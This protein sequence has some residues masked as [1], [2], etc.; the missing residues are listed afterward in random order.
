MSSIS[1]TTCPFTTLT[2][3]KAPF[4]LSN[5]LLYIKE[6]YSQSSEY[7]QAVSRLLGREVD[8]WVS[9]RDARPGPRKAS[10]APPRPA[11]IDKTRGAQRGKADCRLHRLC[12]HIWAKNG[13]ENEMKE[14]LFIWSFVQLV[15]ILFVEK[16]F[17]SEII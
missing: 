12:P 6:I 14:M 9:I 5:V 2:L 10:F 1:K 15:I 3:D 4:L 16:P 7:A 11:E 8:R 13:E 17:E